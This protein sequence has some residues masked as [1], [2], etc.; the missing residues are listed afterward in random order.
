MRMSFILLK[1]KKTNDNKHSVLS[2]SEKAVR[3]RVR[4]RG[5]HHPVT[6]ELILLRAGNSQQGRYSDPAR[7]NMEL[8][9]RVRDAWG[10]DTCRQAFFQSST[11]KPSETNTP[12]TTHS[13]D[14]NPQS[15]LQAHSTSKQSQRSLKVVNKIDPL[16]VTSTE[17]DKTPQALFV[18][19]TSMPKHCHEDFEMT[20]KSSLHHIRLDPYKRSEVFQLRTDTQMEAFLQECTR[21]QQICKN[22]NGDKR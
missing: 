18:R 20:S 14:L 5:P 6:P 4:K 3:E 7:S 17:D 19:Q 15:S 16:N 2:R 8:N 1:D 13:V 10:P 21:Q 12:F 11:K 22:V 9:A